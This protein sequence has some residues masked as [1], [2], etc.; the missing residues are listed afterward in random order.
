MTRSETVT[1]YFLGLLTTI[2]VIALYS[3]IV[4]TIFYSFYSTRKG[5]VDWDSFSYELYTKLIFE[6][7]FLESILNSLYVVFVGF[8]SDFEIA[9]R[10]P[11]IVRQPSSG[12]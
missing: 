1:K 12:Q 5:K 8:I 7:Q 10:C 6:K 3:P 9:Q 2:I 11:N 4:M